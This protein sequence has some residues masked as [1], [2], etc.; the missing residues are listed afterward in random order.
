MSRCLLVT[1]RLHD[2]RYHGAGNWPPSPARLFQ[3][4]VAGAAR[5]KGLEEADAQALRWLEC[6]NPPIVA[7]PFA[8]AGQAITLYVPNND[9][10]AVGGDPRNIGSIRAAESVKPWL[11]E[12]D[13]PLLFFWAADDA[14]DSAGQCGVIERMAQR[15]YQFGRGVDMA[16]ATAEG[17]TATEAEARLA[18][19]R[20]PVFHPGQGA[21]GTVLACPAPGSLDSLMDRHQA[22]AMR[23]SRTDNRGGLLFTQ[24]PKPRFRQVAY[25]SPPHRI[26][27]ELRN[28]TD[29]APWPLRAAGSL[30][31]SLLHAAAT[32]LATALHGA[33]PMIDRLLLGRGA[34]EADKRLR[35]RLVPLPSIGSTY[36]D[37]AIRRVL[38]EVPG[39]CPLPLQDFVWAV[40]GLFVSCTADPQ[41][42]E[43]TAETRLLLVDSDRMLRH[44]GIGGPPAQRW[45]SV[46]PVALPGRPHPPVP[47]TGTART[48]DEQAGAAALRQTLRHAGLDTP[49]A[50]IT[51]RREPFAARGARAEAFAPRTRFT[52][53]RLRHAE[54]D[55]TSP[56]PGPLLLG[57]GRFL[58]LGLFAPVRETNGVHAFKITGGLVVAAPEPALLA[59]ALRR[60]VM[61]RVQERLGDISLPGFFSGH[62]DAGGPLREG[63]QAH[64][65]FTFDPASAILCV[66]AP[67]RVLA[68][69]P[70]AEEVRYL[71]VLDNAL[72]GFARLRAGAAG[73]LTLV[74]DETQGALL[75]GPSARWESATPYVVTRHTKRSTASAVLTEDVAR[76]C[77]RRG[78]S[79]PQV[80]VLAV[81]PGA[82][83]LS[84]YLRLTFALACEGP[85]LLGR[86]AHLG[87]G[88][89]RPVA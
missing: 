29:F 89:F 52:P 66:V 20:G 44:Y 6:Q 53:A 75:F 58:G 2:P 11:L 59:R 72:E 47:W 56:R 62:D 41:T 77:R 63:P 61:A 83:G 9:L 34:G 51:I 26:L 42:G 57:D 23:F 85:L 30:I 79:V 65:L 49:P 46:T 31:Q 32:K 5:G 40:S 69:Q 7:V 15:L 3:A 38:L 71:D 25:E 12:A 82:D 78:L 36:A 19:H 84:G 28:G 68:R 55:F 16:W 37:H 50:T 74:S 73:V 22:Q 86:S 54:I 35:P 17:L 27:F 76:E 13:Q 64:L 45:R 87:G 60:A 4:L 21:G 10:D 80:E 88:L 43:I 70:T 39:P 8:R 33:A 67:H 14:D 81:S 24:P 1:L 48:T 18:A